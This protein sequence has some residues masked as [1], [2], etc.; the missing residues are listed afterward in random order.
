MNEEITISFQPELKD[1][2]RAS[3]AHYRAGKLRICDRIAGSIAILTG[4]LILLLSGWQ[5]WLAILLPLAIVEWSD[6][7]HGH[8]L[9]AWIFFVR[10]PKFRER[11]SLAFHPEG[12]HFKTATIN[13]TVAWTHYESV[14]EDSVIFLLRYGK[15]MYSVIPKRAFATEDDL[16]RFR[17]MIRSRIQ[18]YLKQKY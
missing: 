14:I 5:W 7:L 6:F 1:Q 10:N 13:S 11:Y 2:I 8:T 12:I 9:Q 3:I 16:C 4:L 18:R 17:E 15:S